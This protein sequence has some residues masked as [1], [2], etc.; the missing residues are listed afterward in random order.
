LREGRIQ[1]GLEII[2]N[3]DIVGGESGVLTIKRKLKSE[4]ISGSISLCNIGGGQLRF[5]LY[6]GSVTGNWIA[7]CIEYEQGAVTLLFKSYC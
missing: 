1:S 6:Q 3:C 5:G 4:E 2:S 7:F